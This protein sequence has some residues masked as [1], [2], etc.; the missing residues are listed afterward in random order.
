M[1]RNTGL[2]SPQY[3]YWYSIEIRYSLEERGGGGKK[4]DA[5]CK[6]QKKKYK[7]SVPAQK[8][9]RSRPK[10]RVKDQNTGEVGAII[11]N[12]AVSLEIGDRI[13]E[14]FSNLEK[15]GRQGAK[16]D[17][18]SGRQRLWSKT[19]RRNAGYITCRFLGLLAA[20]CVGKETACDARNRLHFVPGH[21]LL[22]GFTLSCTR[23]DLTF[24]AAPVSVYLFWPLGFSRRCHLPRWHRRAPSSCLFKF[25]D[26]PLNRGILENIRVFRA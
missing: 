15:K 24:P 3:P 7:T 23:N 8:K 20:G 17:R 9:N 22:P 18:L 16:V 10:S 1:F 11:V 13:G 26:P 4:S 6:K 25:T 12:K 21:T 2:S 5:R 19:R 14:G